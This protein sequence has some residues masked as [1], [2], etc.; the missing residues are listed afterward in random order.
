MQ[1]TDIIQVL[2]SDKDVRSN[3][4]SSY[5][6]R[7]RQYADIGKVKDFKRENNRL[8]AL[9]DGNA[10]AP[11]KVEAFISEANGKVKLTGDC[12]CPIGYECKHVIAVLLVGLKLDSEIRSVN[13]GQIIKPDDITS[14][15]S[16]LDFDTQ[17]W[18]ESLEGKH[19]EAESKNTQNSNKFLIYFCTCF[20]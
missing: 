1:D 4:D 3:F 12:S 17:T 7:G 6:F 16:K 11:Y 14:T 5:Y 18:L 20:C 8:T 9:V 13:D 19:K 2:Y 10:D 15:K